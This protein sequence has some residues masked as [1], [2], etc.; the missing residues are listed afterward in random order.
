MTT[1]TICGDASELD[2]GYTTVKSMT[3]QSVEQC[4]VCWQRRR[5][6]RDLAIVAVPFGLLALLALLGG[7]WRTALP[8]IRIYPVLMI[9][10]VAHELGHALV[11]RAVGLRVYEVALGYG[12]RLARLRVGRTDVEGATLPF[13]GHTVMVP[14]GPAR[15]RMALGVLAGPLANL[16]VVVVTVS[17]WPRSGPWVP[18]LVIA[19]T[20]VLVGN[21]WPMKVATPLGR[22]ASDG[23]ALVTLL[24]TPAAELNQMDAIGH[25]A[26]TAIAL[27]RR[28]SVTAVRRA[29]VGLAAH[30]DHRA[31]RH[32]L[33]VGLIRMGEFETARAHLQSLLASDRA[34]PHE[35]AIDLNN[36]AW[37]DLMS[38]DPDLLDEALAASEEAER[39]LAWNPA[40]KGTRGYTLIQSGR[41]ADGVALVRRAYQTHRDRNDRATCAC[42]LAIGA[43]RLGDLT[44]AALDAGG[45]HASRSGVRSA[46]PGHRPSRGHHVARRLNR[47]IA[48]S[49][50][51]ARIVSTASAASSTTTSSSA[52]SALPGR[53]STWSVPSIRPGGLPTP[54]RTRR[55][56]C[57]WRWDRIDARPLLPANPPPSF[58]CI[59]PA[60]KSSSSCTTTSRARSSIPCRRTSA[61]TASPESL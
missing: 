22:V 17:V 47:F 41:V 40:V 57:E 15:L 21:L 55:K 39:K 50:P 9:V 33:T 31:L 8:T 35:H 1:C 61:A 59:R 36:L 5:E 10:V 48:T 12:P 44:T 53:R 56:S 25:A 49:T 19:N 26:E 51:S 20:I 16:A 13:G 29:E 4:A 32:H 52:R 30:P 34:E 60:G 54:M 42:V 18:P 37:A 7:E 3:G 43:A 27:K 2:Y 38:E 24:R 45:S 11:G 58:T 23:L 14:A 46:R 28:D 6:R